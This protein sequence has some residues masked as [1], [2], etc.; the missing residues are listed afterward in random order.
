MWET[1]KKRLENSMF[2]FV[3]THPHLSPAH[4]HAWEESEKHIENVQVVPLNDGILGG[5]IFFFLLHNI[6]QKS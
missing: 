5:L 6:F 3:Y 1:V 4:T 2:A